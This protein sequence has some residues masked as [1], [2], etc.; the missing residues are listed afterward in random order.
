MVKWNLHDEESGRNPAKI[1]ERAGTAA[2][3]RLYRMLHCLL[4]RNKNKLPAQT[5][6]RPAGRFFRART[7]CACRAQHC[8][9]HS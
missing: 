1:Q 4:Y 3:K 9:R 6:C 7:P 2:G 8:T 5:I